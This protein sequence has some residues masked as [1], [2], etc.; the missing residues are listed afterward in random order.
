MGVEGEKMWKPKDL[1]GRIQVSCQDPALPSGA[2]KEACGHLMADFH[3]P[4]AKEIALRWTPD[5][6]EFEEDIV[7]VEFCGKIGVCKDGHK[8]ISQMIG[9]SDGKEKA[10]KRRRRRRS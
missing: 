7:P 9:E 5:S 3:G 4:I 10:I 2:M 6:E 8:T 1:N